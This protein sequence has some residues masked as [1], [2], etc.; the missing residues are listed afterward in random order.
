MSE[1][2]HDMMQRRLHKPIFRH[3]AA[4]TLMEV[5][6]SIGILGVGLVAVASLFP[7]AILL[8]KQASD[9]AL[10]QQYIRSA[11]AMLIGKGLS[12]TVLLNFTDEY[13]N[14]HADDLDADD[15]VFE[16]ANNPAFDVYPLAYV[17]DDLSTSNRPGIFPPYNYPDE[18]Y[19][20][21]WSILDRSFPSI[22]PDPAKRSVYW[23]PLF[24]RGVEASDYI[25]DWRIYVFVMEDHRESIHYDEDDNPDN[26]ACANPWDPEYFP[27]VYRLP[28]TSV[29]N[30]RIQLINQWHG[31][32]AIRAGDMVLG[33]NGLIF[34]VSA[35]DSNF[36]TVSDEAAYNP[37]NERPLRAVWFA[38]AEAPGQPSPIRDIRVL[39][40][41]VT[42]MEPLP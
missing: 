37:T 16:T 29:T 23:V 14:I 26:L 31:A 38:R 42:R 1:A 13:L 39:S 17:D 21:H 35:A 12:A 9:E 28:I 8:Q 27:K 2:S 3:A 41:N 15:D 20:R 10:R 36:I 19:L 24:R 6:V 22:V 7:T 40:N 34:R 5:L 33:D 18:S 32:L 4:F 25:N 30:N 11:D